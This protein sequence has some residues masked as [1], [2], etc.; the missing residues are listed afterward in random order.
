LADSTKAS[1]LR[2]ENK[3][4]AAGAAF[5]VRKVVHALFDWDSRKPNQASIAEVAAPGRKW[6]S[7]RFCTSQRC[8]N[9]LD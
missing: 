1:R 3:K 2:E 9:Q 6:I 8:A 4:Q 5:L 7:S